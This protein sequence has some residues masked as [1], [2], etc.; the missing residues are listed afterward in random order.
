MGS[1]F[2]AAHKHLNNTVHLVERG[3]PIWVRLLL[4]LQ[5]KENDPSL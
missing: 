1:L 2:K 4:I 5:K 3:S